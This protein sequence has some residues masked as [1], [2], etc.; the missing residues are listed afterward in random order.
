MV[1]VTVDGPLSQ[2]YVRL[3]GIEQATESLIVCVI[4]NG[5]AIELAGESGT[6][7][8]TLASLLGL[9][10]TDVGAAI[11]SSPATEPL[12]AIQIEQNHLMAE[13]GVKCDSSRAAAFRVAR[14]TARHDYL[15]D[16]R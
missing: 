1:A 6:G 15:E 7:S 4:D 8:K 12:A 16:C 11:Q 14:M 10:G 13:I 9:F 2:N 3:F 5:A